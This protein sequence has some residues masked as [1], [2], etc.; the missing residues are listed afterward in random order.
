MNAYYR[1]WHS[2]DAAVHNR[3]TCVDHL[4]DDARKY[5]ATYPRRQ[6][7]KRDH[8]VSFHKLSASFVAELVNRD[9]DCTICDHCREQVK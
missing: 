6:T 3:V 8:I 1:Q 4:P 2:R 5:Y 9:A 7:F